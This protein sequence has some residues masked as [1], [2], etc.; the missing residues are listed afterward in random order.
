VTKLFLTFACPPYDRILPLVCGLIQPKG[1]NLNYLPL[2]VSEMFWRQLRHEEFDVSEC[3][4]SSY[5]MLR[6]QGDDRF[7]A[8]PV[9]TSRLFRH[10]SIYVNT[11]RG[12]V[13]PQDLK[14]KV[15]GLPE[16]QITAAVWIRGMLQDEYGFFPG[17]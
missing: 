2:N 7:I 14:G 11:R 6:S 4:L 3:S 12:I 15:V 13:S 16:Y 1:I 5:T 8:I 9:F 17:T 10:A